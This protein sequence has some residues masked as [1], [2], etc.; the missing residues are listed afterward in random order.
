MAWGYEASFT[1]EH[2]NNG[3]KRLRCYDCFYFDDSDKS[4]SKTPRYLP[5][6]GY[7]SWKYCGEFEIKPSVSYKAEKLNQYNNY[8]RDKARN[9]VLKNSYKRKAST[10]DVSEDK[11]KI[12]NSYVHRYA[13]S[14]SSNNMDAKNNDKTRGIP[15]LTKEERSTLP[16][17]ECGFFKIIPKPKDKKLV[18]IKLDDGSL[19]QVI[20][21]VSGDAIYYKKHK[22]PK[23]YLAGVRRVIKNCIVT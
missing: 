19:A 8:I 2:I 16:L 18:G 4:C 9:Q 20:V 12:P 10:V 14:N 6:D 1:I 23:K 3:N 17:I 13:T 21:Y 5:D 22:Y 15:L 11:P 7:D